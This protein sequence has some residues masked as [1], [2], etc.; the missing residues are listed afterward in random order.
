MSLTHLRLN[1]RRERSAVACASKK[2]RTVYGFQVAVYL[3]ADGNLLYMS[4]SKL[5]ASGSLPTL[6]T[7]PGF[8]ERVEESIEHA[9]LTEL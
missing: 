8:K 5:M 9:T 1:S 6:D 2:E 4:F 3:G 7:L